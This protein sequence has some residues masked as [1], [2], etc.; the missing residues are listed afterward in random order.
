[1]N[2]KILLIKY[3]KINKLESL[4]LSLRHVLTNND[5]FLIALKFYILKSNCER[6]TECFGRFVKILSPVVF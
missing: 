2:E 1:M 6:T 4:S 5:V 3:T